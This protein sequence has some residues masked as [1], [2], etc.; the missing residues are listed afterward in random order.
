[1]IDL[2]LESTAIGLLVALGCGLLIGLERE[3]YKARGGAHEPAGIRSFT[4]VAVGGAL[5]QS[6]HPPTL[7]VAG[8]IVV[9]AMA[10]MGYW[11]SGE[12]DPELTTELAL[13]VTYLV[14][15]TSVVSPS[16]GAACGAGLAALLAARDQLHRLSTE[17][18]SDQEVRDLIILAGLSLVVLPLVP[19]GPQR[20]S[21][22]IDPQRLMS[23][24]VLILALQ[25]AGHVATRWLGPRAGRA[26]AGFFSGFVSSTATVAS[27]GTQARAQPAQARSLAGAAV[28]SSAATWVQ[29]LLMGSSL[30]PSAASVLAPVALAGMAT[31]L[32]A[33][34]LLAWRAPVARHGDTPPDSALKLREAFVVA[35]LLSGVALVVSWAQDR[36]GATGLYAGIALAA[37]ADAH[38]PV[39]TSAALFAAGR[40]AEAPLVHCLLLAIG[41][42]TVTRTVTAFAAGGR[43]YALCVSAGLFA[44]TGAAVLA[45]VLLGHFAATAPA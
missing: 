9:G 18:L 19:S 14:G 28:M 42:N 32:A 43:P 23:L 11:K 25:A 4:L 3:R 35:A 6:L 21:G 27:M 26:A 44:G 7:V 1:M 2:N 22:G 40:L 20:W 15:V 33:G 13:F 30:A 45:A 31:A 37:V 29:A 39:A 10:L 17:L 36:F 8:A 24:V 12:H 41:V 38:A 16:L 5:A 34:G